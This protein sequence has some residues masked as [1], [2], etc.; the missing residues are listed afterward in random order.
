[1]RASCV[2]LFA[3]NFVPCQIESR[4][5]NMVV[6]TSK[7][8]EKTA[9][10]FACGNWDLHFIPRLKAIESW[11]IMNPSDSHKTDFKTDFKTD[12][13]GCHTTPTSGTSRGRGAT[14]SDSQNDAC[15]PQIGVNPWSRLMR[16]SSSLW[17]AVHVKKTCQAHGCGK[18]QVQTNYFQKFHRGSVAWTDLTN[19]AE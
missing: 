2:K 4:Q 11:Y 16:S 5:K 3:L 6:T 8:A 1:M 9:N 19:S 18:R 10:K 12:S 13:R 7:L 17:A 15:H 14:C